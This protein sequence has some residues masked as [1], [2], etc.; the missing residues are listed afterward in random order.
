MRGYLSFL[1]VLV[2]SFIL[3][4]MLSLYRSP[5]DLS[6]A[7][8]AERAYGLEMN[9]KE[10]ALECLREGASEG[11]S[12]Y[13][14]SHDI[15]ECVH[16]PDNACVPPSPM[17]PFPPNACEPIACSKCFRESEARAAAVSGAASCL[18]L[19]EAHEFD[20]DFSEDFASPVLESSLR[21]DPLSKN[22][23]S[24]DKV[25]FR[26]DFKFEIRSERFGMGIEAAVPGGFAVAID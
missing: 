21:P 19:L 4:G 26:E 8:S 15:R 5:P 23:L 14:G 7:L 13:S 12:D 17:D 9:V 20:P 16:C 24:L 1:L 18:S 3:A 25:R 11:F 10:A 6:G 22:G 2:G